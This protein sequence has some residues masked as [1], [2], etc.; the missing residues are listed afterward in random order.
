[1]KERKGRPIKKIEKGQHKSKS[2]DQVQPKVEP[3]QDQQPIKCK[4]CAKPHPT[5]KC[6]NNPNN[7]RVAY[8]AQFNSQYRGNNSNWGQDRSHGRVD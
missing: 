5:H 3:K 1:M 7:K 2:V 4:I 8:S 6:W